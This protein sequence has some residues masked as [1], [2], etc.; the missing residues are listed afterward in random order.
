MKRITLLL[1]LIAGTMLTACHNDKDEVTPNGGSATVN[2]Q[3]INYEQLDYDEPSG[4]KAQTRGT[5]LN[6]LSY[7]SMGIYKQETYELVEV[8]HIAK[9]EEGY[10]SFSA[11][12]PYGNYLF[13]FLGYQGSR[14]AQ[15]ESPTEIH[16]ADD[17]V[18]HL[19]YAQTGMTVSSENG[20]QQSVKLQRAVASFTIVSNGTNPSNLA[21]LSI[22]ANGGGHHLNA[23]TGKA[24]SIEERSYT[25]DVSGQAGNGNLSITFYSFLVSNTGTMN[26]T[27]TALDAG[28]GTIQSRQFTNVPMKINQRTRYTGY[29]FGEGMGFSIGLVDDDVD[30][31]DFSY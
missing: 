14:K 22:T 15:M 28:G 23:L 11:N 29:F 3:V 26:F 17:F 7:L 5:T 20:T 25:Y 2:F 19:F 27:V 1:C 6:D 9:D 30:V 10:G 16:F 24:P 8:Q 13:V 21:K 4:V 18:P 12:L 31:V